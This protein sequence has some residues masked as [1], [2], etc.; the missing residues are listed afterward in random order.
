MLLSCLKGVMRSIAET[1][2]PRRLVCESEEGIRLVKK[3]EEREGQRDRQ[4]ER[5]VSVRGSK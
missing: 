3:E 5:V 2:V 4:A 1:K